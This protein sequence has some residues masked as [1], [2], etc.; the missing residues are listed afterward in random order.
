VNAPKRPGPRERLLRSAAALTYE[1]GVAVGVD[2]I[3]EDADVARG[4]LYNH[5][6][7]K[8]QLIAETLRMT[9]QVDEQRYRDALD[10][11]G[12]DPR[13]RLLAV[14]ETLDRT[15]SAQRFR[16]CRYA[17]ADLSLPSDHPAHVET[18]AYKERLQELFA[19]ELAAL[20]HPDPD[21]GASQ[22]VLLIDGVL[23]DAVTRPGTHPA[24]T[25]RELAEHI[26]NAAPRRQQ[27]TRRVAGAA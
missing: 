7:G 11:G 23:A 20:E 25:A 14:F 13:K 26:L 16:G 9:S 6:D 3:L 8:D 17:A 27:K 15:T 19:N 5:F 10:S 2:A 22:I 12:A 24:R 4:S 21:R 18:R 1:H